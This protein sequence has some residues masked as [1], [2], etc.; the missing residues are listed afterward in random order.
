[1][2]FEGLPKLWLVAAIALSTAIGLGCTSD[3]PSLAVKVCADY[4]VFEEIEGV[5]VQLLN[6]EREI[7]HSSV[8]PLVLCPED[9]LRELPYTVRFR[10]LREGVSL[11]QVIALHEGVSFARTERR[12]EGP[13]EV[14]I[15][16]REGCEGVTCSLGQTCVTE[17]CEWTPTGSDSECTGTTI[18]EP[19]DEE[20]AGGGAGGGEAEDIGAGDGDI[21]EGVD[22]GPVPPRY[23]PPEEASL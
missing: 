21:G 17:D 19:D 11:V 7:L 23:C 3:P 4:E 5:R 13:G 8:V 15:S 2:I 16:L 9:R 12:V 6:A 22:A 18:D 1:M 14:T 20:D 10:D